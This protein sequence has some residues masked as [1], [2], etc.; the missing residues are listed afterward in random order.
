MLWC[1]LWTCSYEPPRVVEDVADDEQ[2]PARDGQINRHHLACRVVFRVLGVL[3]EEPVGRKEHQADGRDMLLEIEEAVV[4]A[5]GTTG[6]V[7]VRLVRNGRETEMS[8]RPQDFISKNGITDR[9]M[10]ARFVK[11]VKPTIESC[12]LS[13]LASGASD[14]V[15]L[16]ESRSKCVTDGGFN[17]NDQ[18]YFEARKLYNT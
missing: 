11:N 5:D 3:P 1:S 2:K 7:V 15:A 6:E 16:L 14:Y 18:V 9:P 12:T 13:A 17:A 4:R 10:L 8:F